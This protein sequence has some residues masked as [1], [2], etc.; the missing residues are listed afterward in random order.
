MALKYGCLCVSTAARSV[1]CALRTAKLGG[2]NAPR[3]YTAESAL[4]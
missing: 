3:D 1:F 2:A 4:V